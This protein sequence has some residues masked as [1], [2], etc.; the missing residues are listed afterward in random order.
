M[1]KTY[2][3]T[4]FIAT[5]FILLSGST[6]AQ[7]VADI[8]KL[9]QTI[10]YSIGLLPDAMYGDTEQV[11]E[12]I[13]GLEQ[14]VAALKKE[15]DP[16]II[17]K[18]HDSW[19]ILWY[20]STGYLKQNDGRMGGLVKFI[21]LYYQQKKDK[22]FSKL[23]LP[24]DN[25]FRYY[26]QRGDVDSLTHIASY[27]HEEAVKAMEPSLLMALCKYLIAWSNTAR[28]NPSEAFNWLIEAHKAGKEIAKRERNTYAFTM[29]IEMLGNL[30]QG[31]A[32]RGNHD[33]ALEIIKEME[34]GVLELYH[35]NS[36][37]YLGLLVMKAE[38]YN[39]KGLLEDL[40]KTINLLDSVCQVAQN[41]NPQFLSQVKAGI[42][43]YRVMMGQQE[44]HT[45]NLQGNEEMVLRQ[46][47]MEAYQQGR[48]GEA[49]SHTHSLI[50]LAETQTPFNTQ[51]YSLYIEQLVGL[52]AS[53]RNF[54]SAFASL[55]S[56]E[57]FVVAHDQLD[58]YAVRKI[59][60][61][62][63]S[64]LQNI[65]S[66]KES[67]RLL[68]M[69]KQMYDMAGDHSFQYYT[70]CLLNL[71][72]V[73]LRNGDY[74][75]A[76][77]YLDEVSSYIQSIPAELTGME[78]N[79]Q[80][81]NATMS[82]V[83]ALLGYEGTAVKQ[84]EELITNNGQGLPQLNPSRI[85]LG[86]LLFKQGQYDKAY[87]IFSDIVD[88]QDRD[89]AQ[90]KQMGQLICN[91]ARHDPKTSKHLQIYDEDVRE[92]VK[93]VMTSFSQLERQTFWETQA[94]I[95]VSGN[96]A[97]LHFMPDD[98][99]II[100]L[101]YDNA[102]YVKSMQD[103]QLH[104][105]LRWHD[106]CK[107]LSN[108]E[109]AI[110]FI[111]IPPSYMDEKNMYFGALVL[112]NNGVGPQFIKLCSVETI[113][114]LYRDIIHTD[115]AH[116]NNLYGLENGQLYQLIWKP[117]EHL[118]NAGE[119]IYYTPTG[120]LSQINFDA[121]SNGHS[122]RIGELYKLH[123]VSTTAAIA[124]VKNQKWKTPKEAVVYG[125][126]LYFESE[127]EM[128]AAAAAYEHTTKV[129][130]MLAQRGIGFR[131]A[132]EQLE[133]TQEEALY[134]KENL[135]KRN[136]HVTLLMDTEGN[137]ESVKA[138]HGRAPELLHFGT[139]GF[140]LSTNQDQYQHRSLYEAAGIIG[141]QQQALMLQSGLLLAG[142]YR[143]WQGETLPI[144]V[145]DGILTAYEL[146]Q[147]DLKGCNLV[148][149]SACE[150]GLGF[151]NNSTGDVGLKRALKLAGAGSIVASLWQV[152]DNATS[153]L[154]KSFY[155]YIAIGQSPISAL[156]SAK[157][158]LRQ[159]YPQPY[160]WAGF[161]VVD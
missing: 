65:G 155:D 43:N 81:F 161:F 6:Q 5:I 137:E 87:M 98:K 14:Y 131:G 152:P 10:E 147:I 149:L 30:S 46:K 54:K 51:Q 83:Y 35:D 56:A 100:R 27:L 79:I 77:L 130:N 133:G 2:I 26:M 128:L 111:A 119:K 57:E 91:A 53:E 102:L 141:D 8:D 113:H 17:E 39:T 143:A 95:L 23:Y 67:L 62:R 33:K 66:N 75:Y 3:K 160:Y 9:R 120:L 31:Y 59:Y 126:I 153:I 68:N 44:K 115:T 80:V 48:M 21:Q 93:D 157:N 25:A 158:K 94:Y 52:Y 45:E 145:E 125:G 132:I 107:M 96:N 42:D 134:I 55:Q 28:N 92:H 151:I 7:Q 24:M 142:S 88:A 123:Q 159:R 140:L 89:M 150:T 63:A 82:N 22:N 124:D 18:L 19:E 129:D 34:P 12:A 60:V 103:R 85:L 156:N 86:M 11:E 122:L 38:L 69:A 47:V 71:A 97:T 72:F 36:Q 76:K 16:E 29:Y 1:Q 135:E 139:H 84:L 146:S 101:C 138:L 104:E 74:A 144:N 70:N 78:Y 13:I 64:L 37:Q 127:D 4:I 154:M 114:A 117:L 118:L 112:R 106:V 105:C 20:L 148:V 99:Q 41:V 90:K 40:K 50:Q 121:M 116:I 32:L 49:I 73:S 109:V 136:C 110:E 61:I 58:S 108:D 15:R